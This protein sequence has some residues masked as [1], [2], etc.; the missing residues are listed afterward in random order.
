ME[1]VEFSEPQYGIS[2]V[3]ASPKQSF[4]IGLVISLGLAKDDASAEK[5]LIGILVVSILLT[6]F[7]F[8]QF[9]GSAVQEVPD[10]ML[11]SGS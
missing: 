10:P 6:M 5:V 11:R 7:V 9:G 3:Q 2:R 4:L 8:W 1:S